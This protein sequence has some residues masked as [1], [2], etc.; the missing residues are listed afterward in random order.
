M[1]WAFKIVF[2]RVRVPWLS[3]H[4]FLPNRPQR[5]SSVATC[6]NQWSLRSQQYHHQNVVI[7]ESL[8]C[9]AM[10]LNC[11][12]CDHLCYHIKTQSST[13]SSTC[14]FVTSSLLSN[15]IIFVVSL[16]SLSNH[17]FFSLVFANHNPLTSLCFTEM[18]L[19]QR[20]EHLR[21]RHVAGMWTLTVRRCLPTWGGGPF[22]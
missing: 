18:D 22:C 10:W 11:F 7:K 12:P 13:E 5:E 4:G 9:G 20:T 21:C 14:S 19:T 17:C 16:A 8:G 2:C 3:S 6:C 1:G 15:Q